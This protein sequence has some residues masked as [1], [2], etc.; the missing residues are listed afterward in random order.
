MC[1]MFFPHVFPNFHVS[2]PNL[3]WW[4]WSCIFHTYPPW[5]MSFFPN[6]WP[7]QEPKL[8]VPTIYKAYFSGLCK[9]I[10]PQ[11]MA[12]NMVLTYLRYRILKFPLTLFSPFFYGHNAIHGRFAM[13]P[14]WGVTGCSAAG[15]RCVAPHGALQLGRE[16]LAAVGACRRWSRCHKPPMTGNGLYM[17]IYII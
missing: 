11:N 6:Q 7:F 14:G 9:G 12:R 10:Y 5:N 3:M 16:R 8:E 13:V 2:T 17:F 4:I 1:F 15:G